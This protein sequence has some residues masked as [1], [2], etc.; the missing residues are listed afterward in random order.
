[1]ALRVGEGVIE[2]I[3]EATLGFLRDNQGWAAPVVFVLAFGESL[4]LVSLLLPATAILFG[5]S[6]LL[7]ASGIAFWPCWG[8]AVAGAFLGDWVSYWLG[9]HFKDR[10]ARMWPLSRT[11][12]LLPR[13]ERF[14]ARWG[15]AGVFAGRFFG[16]L[17][18]AVPLAAG[19]CAMPILWFQ[20]ANLGSALVWA[21][22]ILAPGF[23]VGVFLG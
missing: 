2:G 12:E 23:V 1:M 21:T 6:G 10:I 11:P 9:L 20:A 18:A 13:G 8:A 3:V 14:F 16:P 7:G 17:R 22:G 19:S 15:V 4:A 5:M